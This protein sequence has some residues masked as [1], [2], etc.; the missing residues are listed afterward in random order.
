MEEDKRFPGTTKA[1]SKDSDDI[2]HEISERYKECQVYYQDWTEAAEEDY[3][4]SLGD[5]WSQDDMQT[6][7]D[8]NRPALT[9]NRIKPLINLVSGYQRENS[10]RIKVSPEGGEDKVFSEIM[11]KALK[12]IDKWGR[13]SYKLGYQFDDGLYC[14]KGFIEAI[15]NY[16]KDPVRG[17]LKFINLGP[18]KVYVDPNCKEYDINDGAEYCIKHGRFTRRELTKMYPESK[19]EIEGFSTDNDDYM[20][21]AIMQEGDNDNYGNN[22]NSVTVNNQFSEYDTDLKDDAKFTLKEYWYKKY[23]KRYFVIDIE[24]GEPQKFEDKDEAEAFTQQQLAEGV[25]PD[26]LEPMKVIERTVPEMWVCAQVYGHLLMKEKS[27][28]EPLYNGFPFFRFL[29]YWAANSQEEKYAV[30]GITRALIDP[31]KEKN[32]SKSQNLHILNTQANSGWIGDDDAMTEVG[33]AALAKMGAQAGITV[34]KKKGSELREILPKGPNQGQIMRDQQAESEFVQI[35]GI[36]AELLGTSDKNESGRAMAI[37]VKQGITALVVLFNNYR[38]TKEILGKFVLKMLPDLMDAKKLAKVLGPKYM[39]S[40]TL[41]GNLDEQGQPI[42]GISEGNL[43]A[44]LQMVKD[45]KYDV[46]VTEAD[47]GSTMRYEIFS[48]MM[49]MAK[50]GLPIPPALMI[51]YLD[52]GNSDEVKQEVKAYQ[53]QQMQAAQAKK[54]G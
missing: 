24:S 36:H 51:D 43:E 25:D 39:Q 22:P 3:K 29:G 11:D 17:E 27:P 34:K 38:Y 16:D 4:F 32:K 37:R 13:M 5:Q 54:K 44:Y 31:Q 41:P 20:D 21:N 46:E 40:V 6:L 30:Q 18:F 2:R 47:Q 48:Q 50:I 9:F 33:W 12:A 8:Q 14:G 26:V 28:L 45:L 15:I 53:Q 23:V 1:D 7:K 49:E 10:A 42:Q 19:K 52:I 35:S